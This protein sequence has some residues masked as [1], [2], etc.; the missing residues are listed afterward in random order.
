M[1][2][3]IIISNVVKIDHRLKSISISMT[4]FKLNRPFRIYNL[5]MYV[6]HKENINLDCLFSLHLM[7]AR[8]T[9]IIIIHIYK[10]TAFME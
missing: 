8:Q 7:T 10:Y 3:I 2:N 9:N 6:L 5:G 1:Y 4:A